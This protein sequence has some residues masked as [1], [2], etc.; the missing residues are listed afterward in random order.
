SYHLG[1]FLGSGVEPQR[2]GTSTGFIAPYETFPTAEG[3]LMVTA[4]NDNLF[5]A[6]A[7]GIGLADDPR[8]ATNALRVANR[9]ALRD[10][11]VV[12]LST[13]T[14]R[15]WADILGSSVPCTPVR[16]VGELAGDEQLAALDLVRP[17]PTP[18]VPAFA[19]VGQPFQLDGR[20]AA[21]W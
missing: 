5:R 10:R 4:G 3:D 6:F 7:A 20:R 14:A 11:V 13:K 12:A 18:E 16:S 2:A 17:L 19:A 9:Q 21:R 8:F 15:E 1:G